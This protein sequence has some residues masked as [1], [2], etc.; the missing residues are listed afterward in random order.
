MKDGSLILLKSI[1]SRNAVDIDKI[2]IW[3][4]L[5]CGEKG[6]KYFMGYKNDEHIGLMCVSHFQIWLGM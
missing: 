5:T 2:T 1:I 6:F 4:K 3:E